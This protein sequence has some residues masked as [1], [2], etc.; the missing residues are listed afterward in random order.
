IIFR[1]GVGD[2]PERVVVFS[3][4]GGVSEYTEQ[5]NGVV[6]RI[7]VQGVLA[8]VARM[9]DAQVQGRFIRTSWAGGEYREA[10]AIDPEAK[11]QPHGNRLSVASKARP[12][13]FNAR[14]RG[15]R[16]PAPIQVTIGDETRLIHI[17]TDDDDPS[18]EP[19]T[20]AQALRY[21]VYFHG[22]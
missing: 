12:C 6:G 1:D 5:P 14:G 20:W 2:D 22:P 18:A 3:G 7:V 9:M 16:S 10:I 4:Y 21:L 11:T 19:W 13:T 15:N 17:F 8:R